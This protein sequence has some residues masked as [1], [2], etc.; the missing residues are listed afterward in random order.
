[1][2]NGSLIGKTTIKQQKFIDKYIETGN[3]TQ[4][5]LYAYNTTDPLVASTI[6][7]ENLLKPYIM[8]EIKDKL[9]HAKAQIYKLSLGA[10]K[11]DIRLRAS[12]DILDRTEGK[13]VQ[14]IKTQN[15]NV[16]VE[17]MSTDDLINLLKGDKNR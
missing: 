4:S 17:D 16:N 1:M 2:D 12:Q 14:T 6:A 3:W 7:S 10:E 11:E 15:V 9:A 13:A 8:V 5:A